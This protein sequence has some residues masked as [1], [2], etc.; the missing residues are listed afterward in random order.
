MKPD[1]ASIRKRLCR[2]YMKRVRKIWTKNM[3]NLWINSGNKSFC[4]PRRVLLARHFHSTPSVCGCANFFF[5]EIWNMIPILL[6]LAWH[7]A[8]HS[9][10]LN[11]IPFMFH[12]LFYAS[13]ELLN[14]RECEKQQPWTCNMMGYGVALY[15]EHCYKIYFFF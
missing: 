2:I 6:F 1:L 9:F 7:N 11:M 8:F 14:C 10:S 13:F 3:I 4:G 15:G 12:Q 5:L